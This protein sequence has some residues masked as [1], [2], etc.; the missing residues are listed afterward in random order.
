M[1]IRTKK[2]IHEESETKLPKL[3]NTLTDM[4]RVRR[5]DSCLT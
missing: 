3:F 2:D 1:Y 4:C 5:C